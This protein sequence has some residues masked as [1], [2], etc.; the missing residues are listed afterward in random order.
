MQVRYS[1]GTDYSLRGITID[2]S[3]NWKFTKSE[4]VQMTRTHATLK[5]RRNSLHCRDIDGINRAK[6]MLLVCIWNWSYLTSISAWQVYIRRH[7]GRRFDLCL[8]TLDSCYAPACCRMEQAMLRSVRLSVCLSVPMSGS[9]PFAR[10]R[11]TR[12]AVSN[13]FD[14]VAYSVVRRMNEVR[15]LCVEP[16]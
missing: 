13:A 5:Y 11:Y 1:I 16:G 14:R 7:D 8:I 10:W 6:L 9:V 4:I 2:S 3:W 15:L 12:V